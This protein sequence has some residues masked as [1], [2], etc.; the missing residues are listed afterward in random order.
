MS[1][2]A[3]PHE[4]W[5]KH[6]RLAKL[7]EQLLAGVDP[8]H[9]RGGTAETPLR[10]ARAWCEWTAGYAVDPASLLK[11]FDDGHENYDS[12]VIVHNIP[13]F[14][15]CEHHLAEIS[16]Y[17]HVG[18]LPGDR[19]VG[20]SKL[21]R[22]A[23][24]FARRLQVQERMTTQIAH[25]IQDTLKARATGVII[26]ARHGCMSTRGACVQNAL[27]T[28]SCMLGLLREEPSARAEFMSLCDA[29]ERA[30]D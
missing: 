24:A 22:V 9:P 30:R 20:I 1:K 23:D 7:F 29:A 28:T 15:H 8:D 25:C 27:T 17:A 2:V 21:A 16:G 26:R 13:I 11:T 10:A 18:Y 14:S 12:F 19:I 3:R 5:P 4:G 6:G